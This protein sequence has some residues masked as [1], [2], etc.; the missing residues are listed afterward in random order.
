M[1]H[2]GLKMACHL[3]SSDGFKN[4]NKQ[5]LKLKVPCYDAQITIF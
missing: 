4:K 2:L 3:L 5:E 1:H